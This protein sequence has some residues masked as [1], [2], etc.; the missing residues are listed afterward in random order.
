MFL[1]HQRQWNSNLDPQAFLSSLSPT[2]TASRPHPAL[3]SAIY[4]IC[5]SYFPTSPHISVHRDTFLQMAL[6][7]ISHGLEQPDRLTDIVRASCL[8]SSFFYTSGR[9]QEGYFHSTAAVRLAETLHFST[10]VSM[11]DIL[12]Y[13]EEARSGKSETLSFLCQIFALDKGWSVATGLPPALED[14]DL[15]TLS[16]TDDGHVSPSFSF[17]LL[18]FTQGLRTSG[19]PPKKIPHQISGWWD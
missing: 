3:L 9:I 7:G 17:F 14:D 16:D 19:Q 8:L 12:Q 10:R 15:W 1:A 4:L 5:S 18:K 6:S 11:A 2:T 13:Q